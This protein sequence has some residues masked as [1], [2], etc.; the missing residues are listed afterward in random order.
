MVMI[1]EGPQNT[2]A[3]K[4]LRIS[5]E[6]FKVQVGATKW[7]LDATWPVPQVASDEVTCTDHQCVFQQAKELVMELIRDQGFRE[8]RG[9]YGSRLG[10]DSLDVS[11]I[12]VS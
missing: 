1:Q 5:G 6:L 11:N 12:E 3:D 4:P 8:Q 7:V 9:E 2:G 10:G